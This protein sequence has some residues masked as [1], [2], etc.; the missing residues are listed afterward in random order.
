MTILAV[1]I[2]TSLLISIL[3]ITEGMRSRNAAS[4][5]TG[6]QDII[7]TAMGY[8]EDI[9][10]GREIAESLENDSVNVSFASPMLVSLLFLRYKEYL[11]SLDPEYQKHLID[12]T[13]NDT[14]IKVFENN[15]LTLSN[16]A[17]LSKIDGGCWEIVDKTNRYRIQYT[18][19]E[20]N[21]YYSDKPYL[22]MA[23]GVIPEK[24]EQFLSEEK[25]IRLFGL[26][27]QFNEWFETPGDPHFNDSYKGGYT[28]EI[29]ISDN[30]FEGIG[31]KKGDVFTVGSEN[32]QENVTITGTFGS[33]LSGGG[34]FGKYFQGILMMHLS[35]L[36]SLVGAHVVS[37]TGKVEDRISSII[38]SVRDE[39]K[40]ASEI[41]GIAMELRNDYPFYSVLT[42]SDQFARVEQRSEI[43]DIFYTSAGTVSLVI[44]LLFVACI[45]VI[46]VYERQKEIGVMRA[47][48]ISK[49]TIFTQVFGESFVLIAVGAC[50]G[51]IPGYFGSDYISDFMC[52][53]YGVEME[54]TSFSLA[55]VVRCVLYVIVIGC[56]FSFYPA[57]KASRLEIIDAMKKP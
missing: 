57:I 18:G 39:K 49:K 52:A 23:I 9:P 36:Q 13:V 34:I 10:H 17:N 28:G 8:K 11:F 47:I 14:L 7:I 40:D 16:K 4:I 42:K 35:E 1:M 3:S 38:I 6:N 31:P 37:D 15:S 24:T 22:V 56:L 12:G 26:E 45:M 51:I 46:N 33:P 27:M 19:T 20:L 2:S 50:V 25:A 32:S 43:A 53:K 55:L 48:G 29:L 21:I 5:E 41:D 30:L 44:G 54:I